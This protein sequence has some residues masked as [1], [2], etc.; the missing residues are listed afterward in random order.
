MIARCRSKCW[1]L[2]LKEDGNDDVESKNAQRGV[3]GHIIIYPQ[4]PSA[5]ANSLPPS[6]EEITSPICVIFVGSSPPT[7]EW[8]REKAYPLA[9]NG[10]RVRRA[11]LWLKKNNRLYKDIVIN[12]NVL[13]QLDNDPILPFHIEHVLPS[14]AADGLTSGYS[15]PDNLD[16]H[17]THQVPFQNVVINDIQGDATSNQLRAA[18]V[19]HFK[20]KMGDYIDIPHDPQPA[21]E[22]FNPDLLP[23]VYPTLFPYGV[24][25]LDDRNRHHAVSMKQHL[26]S[27]ILKVWHLDL[28]L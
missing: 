1:I 19:R 12:E 8:L 5:L 25:G 27:R 20:N 21:K 13:Q 18:A 14:T 6:I 26:R 28:H 17:S 22:F 4:K 16:D 24:G 7:K 3:K 10:G 9:V 2:Q 15:M 23:M 11:L